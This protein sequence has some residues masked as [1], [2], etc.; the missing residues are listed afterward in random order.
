MKKSMYL[1]VIVC[2]IGVLY[3]SACS[4]SQT[5][6]EKAQRQEQQRV[7]AQAAQDALTNRDFVFEAN[8]IIF[9]SGRP[10]SAIPFTNFIMMQGEENVVIQVTTSVSNPGPNSIGGITIEGRANNVQQSTARNGNLLLDF[11][12]MAA[13]GLYRV[14]VE[15]FNNSDQ[16]R[17]TVSATFSADQF[18]FEGRILPAADADVYKGRFSVRSPRRF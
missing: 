5:A 1:K 2:L 16:G 8:R 10:V 11:Q 15:L 9:R 6:E 14:N 4:T 12:V 3:L 13:Q 18:R 7:A 17:V